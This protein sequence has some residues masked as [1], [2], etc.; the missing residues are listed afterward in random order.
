VIGGRPS[1]VSLD[2]SIR[3]AL[4]LK[5]RGVVGWEAKDLQLR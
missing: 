5:R 2:Q 1:P 3:P 4:R